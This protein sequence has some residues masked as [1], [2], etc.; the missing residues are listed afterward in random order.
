MACVFFRIYGP[1]ENGK[2]PLRL[3]AML[4]ASIH[5]SCA[6]SILDAFCLR[7]KYDDYFR[8]VIRLWLYVPVKAVFVYLNMRNACASS[9]NLSSIIICVQHSVAE[10]ILL[11]SIRMNAHSPHS[12]DPKM[13]VQAL[14][15][16]I[17]ANSQ[18]I[19]GK[20]KIRSETVRK[21]IRHDSTVLDGCS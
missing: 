8:N 20:N 7:N 15:R 6:H 12:Y 2:L 17:L 21:E 16:N 5:L 13:V 14:E 18:R 1:T 3:C 10:G 11:I 9:R 19:S 4:F